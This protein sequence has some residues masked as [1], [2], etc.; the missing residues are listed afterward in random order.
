MVGDE[1][2]YVTKPSSGNA[3]RLIWAVLVMLTSLIIYIIYP[4][5]S[6]FIVFLYYGGATAI[7]T[8]VFIVLSVLAAKKPETSVP[9]SIAMLVLALLSIAA[10]YTVLVYYLIADMFFLL[11]GITGIVRGFKYPKAQRE[12]LAYLAELEAENAALEAESQPES[13]T[14]TEE[15]AEASEAFETEEATEELETTEASEAT[16]TDEATEESDESSK[17]PSED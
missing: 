6:S 16:E 13:P 14:A 10:T 4:E 3:F 7:L 2:V 9:C 12:Y 15:P 1:K 8:A 11:L 17:S 5:I